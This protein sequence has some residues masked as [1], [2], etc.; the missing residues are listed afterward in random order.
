VSPRYL[1]TSD[2]ARAV[3]V[4]PN[5]VR[6]YESWGLLP[7]IPRAPNG[8]RMYTQNH[9]DQM[10]LA[11]LAM[12]ITWLGG[13]I[14]KQALSVVY[15]GVAGDLDASLAQAMALQDLIRAEI[16]YAHA[17]VDVLERWAQG[18]DP[19]SE[20]NAPMTIGQVAQ[21]MSVTPDMLRGWER[22]G[23]LVV[24]RDPVNRYRQYG[25]AEVDRLR[26][27]RALRKAGYSVMAILRMML[28][29]DRGQRGDLR[30]VLDTPRPDEDARYATDRWISA[31]AEVESASQAIIDHLHAMMSDPR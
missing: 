9:V 4:H 16:A 3:G 18:R 22:N 30:V 7:P 29:F 23:L 8:Y 11:R 10:R 17:A 31:L 28:A 27:I 14:R 2:V 13:T 24:P 19:L 20:L 12:R 15:S 5:T 25:P 21:Y 26:V 6:L 1:R